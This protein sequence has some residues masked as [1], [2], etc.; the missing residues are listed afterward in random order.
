MNKLYRQTVWM[1]LKDNVEQRTQQ[2]VY[3]STYVVQKQVKITIFC[4]A[5]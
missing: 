5:H 1:N 3:D 4:N 2:E